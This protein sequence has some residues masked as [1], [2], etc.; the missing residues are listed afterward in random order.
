VQSVYCD[1]KYTK[2][3]KRMDSVSF[4]QKVAM[5]NSGEKDSKAR[6]YLMGNNLSIPLLFVQSIQLSLAMTRIR[7]LFVG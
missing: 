3:K 4:K 2:T 6:M 7:A 5:N 1:E